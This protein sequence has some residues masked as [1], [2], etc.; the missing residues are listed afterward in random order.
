MGAVPKAKRSLRVTTRPDRTPPGGGDTGDDP[1]KPGLQEAGPTSEVMPQPS[2]PPTTSTPPTTPSP[3][4]RP[5]RGMVA[6]SLCNIRYHSCPH[7]VIYQIPLLSLALLHIILLLP[8]DPAVVT[9]ALSPSDFHFRYRRD[10]PALAALREACRDAFAS[11]P[12]AAAAADDGQGGGSGGSGLGL[13]DLCLSRAPD[14]DEVGRARVVEEYDGNDLLGPHVRLD[15]L[16]RVGVP[17]LPTL[18]VLSCSPFAVLTT[19]RPPLQ[20][21]M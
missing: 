5:P 17:L 11:A 6:C 8:Q 21:F 16:V 13:G 4:A 10:D 1:D 2:P 9:F 15:F 20:S 19:Y 18:A 14:R 12:P 3:R 7:L